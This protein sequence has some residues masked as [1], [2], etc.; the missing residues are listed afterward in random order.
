MEIVETQNKK[1]IGY[2]AKQEELWK[3][4]KE[5]KKIFDNVGQSRS[6]IYFEILLYMFL[7]NPLL[8]ASNKKKQQYFHR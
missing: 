8:K 3:K 2:I 1:V 7:K 5:T 4:F 6:T